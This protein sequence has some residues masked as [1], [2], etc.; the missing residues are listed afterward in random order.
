MR[1]WKNAY[2][3]RALRLF[4]GTVPFLFKHVP[5]LVDIRIA[6]SGLGFRAFGFKFGMKRAAT[7]VQMRWSVE[8]F[9]Q[10][11]TPPSIK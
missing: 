1:L 11:F 2:R 8:G 6:L 4:Q 10:R 3:I 5:K 7:E 9:S